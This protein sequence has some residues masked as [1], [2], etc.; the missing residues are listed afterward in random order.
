MEPSP[1][2]ELRSVDP[3]RGRARRYRMAVCRTLF[4][5]LGLLITWGRI[6]GPTRVRLEAFESA[7]ELAERQQQLL[8]R[9]SAHGYEVRSHVLGVDKPTHHQDS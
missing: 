2:L 3:A 7:A 4:G 1:V 8:A 9:R 6:G 5:E